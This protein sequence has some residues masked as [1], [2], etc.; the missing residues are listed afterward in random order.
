MALV[1]AE[2]KRLCLMLEKSLLSSQQIG[3][4]TK[5][6]Q[7]K[8]KARSCKCGALGKIRGAGLS[9]ANMIQTELALPIVTKVMPI[10]ALWAVMGTLNYLQFF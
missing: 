5:I 2:M 8:S 9:H 10:G 1:V 4:A 7:N 6:G 3:K